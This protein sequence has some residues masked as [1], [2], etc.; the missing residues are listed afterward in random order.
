MKQIAIRA[1]LILMMAGCNT[2][3]GQQS[4]ALTQEDFDRATQFV[5]DSMAEKVYRL[6]VDPEWFADG[7]GFA[8]QT[9]TKE[10]T[11]FFAVDFSTKEKKTGFDR[12]KLADKL[13]ELTGEEVDASDLHLGHRKW[14]NAQELEFTF[15]GKKYGYDL[16][17]NELK[18]LDEGPLWDK[19]RSDSPDGKYRVF[20]EDYNL[21]LL[22]KNTGRTRALTRGG[23]ADYIYGSSY[24]WDQLMIGESTPPEP[25]LHVRWS[26][27]GK[28]LFTQIMDTRKAE[29]MYLLDWSIDS[30]YRPRLLSYFRGSPGDTTVVHYIP[31]IYE[32][33]TGRETRLK[34]K[35]FPHFMDDKAGYGLQWTADSHYLYGTFDR[36]GYQQKDIIKVDSKTG[37]IQV[38]YEDKSKTNIDYLTR[39]RLLESE[40]Q[41]L[42]TSER[43]GWKHL[44]KVDFNTGNT[45]AITEGEFVVK[46]IVA[47]D[48]EKGVIYM[49]ISGK[50]EGVNPYYDLLYSVKLDGSELRLLTEEPVNHE[51]SISTDFE[52]F[53]DN[54]STAQDPTVSVLRQTKDGEVVMQIDEADVAELEAMGWKPP[55]LFTATAQDGK[56]EIHGALWKPTHFDESKSYPIIDYTYTGP[57]M[58]VFPNTFR[59]GVYGLYNSVQALAELGFVVMQVD[60]MGSAGRSKSFHNVSYKNM[61]NNL[62]DHTLAIQQLGEKY[63]WIDADRVGIFGH[64]AGGYDAAHALLVFNDTYKVAISEAADHDW[65]MEK[66]WWPEMYAGWPV[67]EVYQEQSNVTLAPNLKGKLFLIHGGIDENV[68]PSAT[69]KLSEALIKADKDFDLLIIPSARH[70]IPKDYLLYVQKRRWKYFVDNLIVNPPQ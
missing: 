43:T 28:Q 38:L 42:I 64:S 65:R 33:A 70:P 5:W 50:E 30:L 26:P 45:Q 7:S 35:P 54:Q 16:S 58:N 66:A 29:K 41:A 4:K 51:V 2:N 20:I 59:K 13:K 17:K 14:K 63:A 27:D 31:V 22:D 6:K 40:D 1:V 3:T 69:F 49:L 23:K 46:D 32:V 37:E 11:E 18:V 8:Y 36:R 62:K 57:H 12:K 55:Q 67:D 10:G 24:G 68:N 61:G 56:T 25:N 34:M 53:V 48:E 9:K 47:V 60:G 15:K 39:F 21:M 19:D 44:Y 52:Y